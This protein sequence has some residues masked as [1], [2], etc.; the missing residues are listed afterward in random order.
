MP[1]RLI[2]LFV[3]ILACGLL[4]L[5]PRPAAAEVRRC[6]T[7]GGQAIFTDRKCDEVGAV[8][9]PPRE[10][11]QAGDAR[12]HRGGGCAR[13]LQDLVFEMNMAIDAHDANRLASVYH[14]TGLS[15]DAGYQIWT[16]LEAI[17]NRPLVDIVP[18]MTASAPPPPPAISN[19]TLGAT[20]TGTP[21]DAS[22]TS[23]S[24]TRIEPTASVDGD[25]YPQ[26]TIRRD[27]VALRVEQTLGNGATPS[28]TVF[29]LT[30]HFGCWWLRF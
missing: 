15:G 25:L 3:L 4:G 12:M 27:P 19:S 30:R 11:G 10:Q 2:F 18:V 8:E 24:R 13:N 26:S 9:S 22:A 7:S 20:S 29:S 28:R 16:R 23:A 14:W 5:S 1:Y 21:S 17:A 6:V